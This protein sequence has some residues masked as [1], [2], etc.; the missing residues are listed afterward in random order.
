[1]TA[2]VAGGRRWMVAAVDL[3]VLTGLIAVAASAVAPV[4][5]D[6]RW[7]A[8][9]AGGAVIGGTLAGVVGLLRWHWSIGLVAV[10]FG[11]FVFGAALATPTAAASGLFPTVESTHRLAVGVI[12]SWRQLLTVATPVGSSGTLLLPIYLTA[13][14]AGCFALSVTIRTRR[15][16]WAVLAPVMMMVIS[17]LL[18]DSAGNATFLTGGLIAVVSLVW[19]AWRVRLTAGTE[20]GGLDL[21]RPLSA[22]LVLTAAGAGAYFVAPR[23]APDVPRTALRNVVVP[24][25]DPRDYPSPL[26]AFRKYVKSD[27]ARSAE[28]LTVTGLPKDGRIRLAALDD[29]DGQVFNVSTS[30][31]S[32]ARVGD[33]V[34]DPTEG[35]SVIVTVTLVDY[36]GIWLP[37][38]GRMTGIAF[39]GER[40]GE[41]TDALRYSSG[42]ATGVVTT[43]LRRGDSYTLRATVP[44]EPVKSETADLQVGA[45]PLPAP[46]GVPDK[47]KAAASTYVD[48]VD[49]TFD[50]V[51]ALRTNLVDKGLF[52]H[53]DTSANEQNSPSGH[54]A[55]RLKRLMDDRKMVGDQEQFAAAMTLMARTLGL[56]ARVVMGFHA[57]DT[58]SGSGD[59][60]VTGADMSAWVEVYFQDAGWVTFDPTPEVEEITQKPERQSTS[61]PRQQ[62]LDPPPPPQ[63]PEQAKAS[64]VEDQEAN[65]EDEKETDDPSESEGGTA[66]SVN[67]LGIGAAVGIP[68]LL[69]GAPIA[70]VL[71]LKRRRRKHRRE[72]PTTEERIAGGWAELVDSARDLGHVAPLV[73][74]RTEVAAGL[75]ATFAD[76]VGRGTVLLARQADAKVF[77]PE[78][79]EESEVAEFWALVDGLTREFGAGRSRWRRVQARL[80]TA[81]LRHR[82]R[83]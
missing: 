48:G 73:A 70:V 59:L 18:G 27:A 1:M 14:L 38:V 12:T 62:A 22:V 82:R 35:E 13:L 76:E 10:T 52:S 49:S 36:Q 30:T 40:A 71:L 26:A 80:S 44:P 3:V 39:D 8:A 75:G 41:L 50:R 42:S 64:D 45:V 81:S 79:V 72:A 31:G 15:P 58:Y 56:P 2:D 46:I 60:V 53:G 43:G 11:Y 54:G 57:P 34:A 51:E 33:R 21:R 61:S 20:G 55:Y 83:R 68:L 4:Y 6:L 19:A 29:Y 17:A 25:F 47:V 69:I 77:G 65:P 5:G 23:V 78:V 28:M 74:T 7:L 24:P 37:E 9:A 67:W 32:F 63:A 66:G 16:F